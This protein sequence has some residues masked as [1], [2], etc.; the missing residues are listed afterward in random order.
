MIECV[1]REITHKVI[2]EFEVW[3]RRATMFVS[4]PEGRTFGEELRS[5]FALAHQALYEEWFD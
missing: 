3:T 1:A 2:D 5:I 4:S